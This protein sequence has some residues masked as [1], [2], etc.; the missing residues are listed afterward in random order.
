MT[1]SRLRLAARRPEQKLG[2]LVPNSHPS[3]RDLAPVQDRL[4]LI[5]VEFPKHNDGRGFS[6]GRMLRQQG[7][8]GTLRATG[9]IL[10]DQF[11]F[12]LHDGFDEVEIDEAQAAA[13]AGRAMAA[14][15]RPDQRELPA[16]RGRPRNHLP[17]AAGGAVSLAA[18]P[19]IGGATPGERLASLRAALPGRIVFTTSFGIEDQAD[20]A[21]HLHARSSRSRWRR[22][23]PAGCFPATYELWEETEE[24][25]G[26]RIRSF[27][28][29]AAAL[30][31]M[32]ADAGINGFYHLEGGAHRL[33]LRAQGRAA[34][35]RACRRERLGDRASRR[36]IGAN[37]KAWRSPAGTRSGRWSSS[38]APVRLDAR[39]RSPPSARAEA[40]R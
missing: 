35:P 11:G 40:C 21:S 31:A 32:V 1:I 24:R 8:A 10:P 38:N 22:S 20:R 7:F 33:L 28:P 4:D 2:V 3:A 36:S 34:R 9:H 30:A 26:V 39:P 15:P 19:R 13:P 37:G 16:H 14:R 6:L 23:T 29:D 18:L 25:Y 12:A 17:Q 5:A 27:H